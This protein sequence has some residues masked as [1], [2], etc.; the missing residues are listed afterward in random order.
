[1]RW[2]HVLSW[3]CLA[4]GHWNTVVSQFALCVFGLK[5][6]VCL[7]HIFLDIEVFVAIAI[8]AHFLSVFLRFG[9]LDYIDKLH[10]RSFFWDGF[11]SLHLNEEIL[12]IKFEILIALALEFILAS[13]VEV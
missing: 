6:L 5:R 10:A 4:W 13:R 7:L 1:M 3:R 11:E 8:A 2:V 9:H 12:S